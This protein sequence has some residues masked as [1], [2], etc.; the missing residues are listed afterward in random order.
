MEDVVLELERPV[1][2]RKQCMVKVSA[3]IDREGAIESNSLGFT[4]KIFVQATLPHRD[5]GP[6][7]LWGRQNGDFAFTIQPGTK[8]GKD[9]SPEQIGLPYGTIPRL[10]LIWMATEATRTKKRELTLGHTLSRFMGQIGLIP[11]GG[12]WG[13]VTRLKEQM[14][15]LFSSRISFSFQNR[16][17]RRELFAFSPMNIGK[18]TL[19][20]D[21]KNYAQ[22]SLFES[23]L[24]LSEEFFNQLVSSPVPIDMRAIGALRQ[25]PLELDIYTWLTHRMSYLR[26]QTPT[27]FW[28]E[29]ATQF[30]SE[31]KQLRDFRINFNRCVKNVLTVY[32]EA[33]IELSEGG[34]ILKPGKTHIKQIPRFLT[35]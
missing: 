16:E 5:P 22:G 14:E 23:S 18:A 8:P 17:E 25:S 3:E 33:R 7:P 15:R 10:L 9:G 20:W 29:L 1:R 21:S 13:T 30:G 27:I 32:P 12:R 35:S 26:R 19:W 31:Y 24:V 6:V 28:E 11:T 2:T 4:S 34:I